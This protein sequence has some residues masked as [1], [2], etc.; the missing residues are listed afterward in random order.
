[1]SNM[2]GGTSYE[3]RSLPWVGWLEELRRHSPEWTAQLAAADTRQEL[4]QIVSRLVMQLLE[5][6]VT[7]DHTSATLRDRIQ[8]FMADNLHRGVTLKDLSAFLGYS[9][10]YCSELFLKVMGEPFSQWLKRLRVRKAE[11]LLVNSR[12]SMTNIAAS[13]GFSDQFSFSHFFK[14]AVGCSPRQFRAGSAMLA[15]P[16][17]AA[18][19]SQGERTLS[20]NPCKAS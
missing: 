13:L 12:V 17:D 3:D 11:H 4:N 19:P 10:K 1:M 6:I 7:L 16:R 14:K 20:T 9:E 2:T 8:V 18:L 15:R 5:Q